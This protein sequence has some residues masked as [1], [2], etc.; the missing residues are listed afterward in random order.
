MVLSLVVIL[1][2]LAAWYFFFRGD[3]VTAAFIR[4]AAVDIGAIVKSVSATGTLQATKTVQ[5]GSQVSGTIKALYADFNSRVTK[6]QLVAELVSRPAL[7]GAFRIAALDDEA[8]DHPVK[9][10]PVEV[11]E[12][13]QRNEVVDRRG[14]ILGEQV[15]DDLP[16]RG[17]QRRGVLF[18]G[19][20]RHR[21]RG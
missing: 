19:V 14:R 13:G 11:V 5:V 8:G 10:D 1:A 6:G 18:V 9:G 21:W 12:P 16:A 15:A 20:Y 17:L 4:F 7:A 2:G 3:T